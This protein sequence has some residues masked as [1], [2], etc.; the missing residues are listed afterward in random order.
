MVTGRGRHGVKLPANNSDSCHNCGGCIN[1][2]GAVCQSC[3]CLVV[4]SDDALDPMIGPVNTHVD[5]KKVHEC[6]FS[7][8]A[9]ESEPVDPRL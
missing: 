7:V 1:P 5:V 8:L 9:L 4:D 3:Y 2:G 6:V